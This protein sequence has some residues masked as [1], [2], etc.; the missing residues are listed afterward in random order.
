MAES[1][2]SSHPPAGRV[3]LKR[4][5]AGSSSASG[6]VNLERLTAAESTSAGGTGESQ[7]SHDGVGTAAPNFR[8]FGNCYNKYFRLEISEC[9]GTV[10]TSKQESSLQ[11][12]THDEWLRTFRA[13]ERVRLYRSQISERLE[14]VITSMSPRNFRMLGNC[15]NKFLPFPNFRRFENCYNKYFIDGSGRYPP[16]VV[17]RTDSRGARETDMHA[18]ARTTH[19]ISGPRHRSRI[20]PGGPPGPRSRAAS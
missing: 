7:A 1:R 10:I 3:N 6:K 14:T 17:D 12:R 16:A 15:H 5:T 20:W 4:V 11:F 19:P 9:L 18:A 2:R 13:L 8:K